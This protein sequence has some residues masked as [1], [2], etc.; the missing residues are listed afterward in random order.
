MGLGGPDWG[1]RIRLCQW[2]ISGKREGFMHTRFSMHALANK[3]SRTKSMRFQGRSPT[4]P[5][6]QLNFAPSRAYTIM[7]LICLPCMHAYGAHIASKQ[8]SL[9]FACHACMQSCIANKQ[10]E[11]KKKR[12]KIKH[13]LH[14][15]LIPWMTRKPVGGKSFSYFLFCPDGHEPS[16]WTADCVI[17]PRGGILRMCLEYYTTR[18]NDGPTWWY[19]NKSTFQLDPIYIRIG[20]YIIA[21]LVLF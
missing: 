9:W 2:K 20:L 7:P 1:N 11:R 8:L 4:G 6:P 15:S 3:V 17:G 16:Q 21:R 5:W 19:I 12:K 18:P 13:E 14:A 10:K